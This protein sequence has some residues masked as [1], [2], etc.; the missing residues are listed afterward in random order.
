[1]FN[2]G[3]C[4]R[5]QY[6]CLSFMI[7]VP[8]VIVVSDIRYS[9]STGFVLCGR[10][11]RP[12][13]QHV[14]DPQH[15]R[16]Q[17]VGRTAVQAA[18]VAKTEAHN[19]VAAEFGQQRRQSRPPVPAEARQGKDFAGLQLTTEVGRRISDSLTTLLAVPSIYLYILLFFRSL[20]YMFFAP[21]T[22]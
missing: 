14:V 19:I 8:M 7:I 6:S 18:A 20:F 15:E 4:D 10:R 2:V 9:R 5:H 3:L 17:D 1:M 11:V 22:R 12:E 21:P 16:A 13:Q